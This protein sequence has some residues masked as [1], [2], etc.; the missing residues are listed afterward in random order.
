MKKILICGSFQQALTKEKWSELNNI[1]RSLLQKGY[2]IINANGNWLGM[3]INAIAMDY[4]IEKGEF[5][6][7]KM[8]QYVPPCS[9]LKLNGIYTDEQFEILASFHKSQMILESN[10]DI[11]MFIGGGDGTYKEYN[12]RKLKEGRPIPYIA[13][14]FFGGRSEELYTKLCNRLGYLPHTKAHASKLSSLLSAISGTI[15]GIEN[16]PIIEAMELMLSE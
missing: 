3:Y 12:L 10:V 16:N 13:L 11:C 2:L 5:S 1:I 9:D 14:P 8:V 6:H 7:D 15:E 4:A